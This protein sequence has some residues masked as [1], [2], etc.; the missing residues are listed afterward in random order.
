M[1]DD[2]PLLEK[3]R[4]MADQTESPD[5][6]EIAREMIKRMLSMETPEE[7]YKRRRSVFQSENDSRVLN[8]VLSRED[9]LGT[10]DRGHIGG[11]VR[12]QTK[13]GTWF[14]IDVD[15]MS[16]SIQADAIEEKLP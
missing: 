1:P 10:P 13:S 6:A 14:T 7:E 9:I 8:Q 3:L 15:E 12:M 16:I 11:T 4:A 2:R 5:E